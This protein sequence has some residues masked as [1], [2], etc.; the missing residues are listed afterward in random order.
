M[1]QACHHQ[2]EFP[3]PTSSLSFSLASNLCLNSRIVLQLEAPDEEDDFL[4]EEARLSARMDQGLYSLQQC[5]LIVGHLWFVGD[6]GVRKRILQLL[7]QKVRLPAACLR[8]LT[9][10]VLVQLGLDCSRAI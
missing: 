10:S 4:D 7:H 6:L 1:W 5:A 8:L 3:Q 9:M 2:K